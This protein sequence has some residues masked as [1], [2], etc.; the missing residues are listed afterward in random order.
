MHPHSRMYPPNMSK[1]AN[2]KNK[3]ATTG[4]NCMHSERQP[5]CP[6]HGTSTCALYK[7]WVLEGYERLIPGILTFDALQDVRISV[8][9]SS[10]SAMEQR[11]PRAMCFLWT[12]LLSSSLAICWRHPALHTIIRCSPSVNWKMSTSFWGSS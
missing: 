3:A 11:H 6:W 10:D 9:Q 1:I 8:R 5:C 12:Q 2:C 4:L 7:R